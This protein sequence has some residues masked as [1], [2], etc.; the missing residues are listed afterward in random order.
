MNK[1][2]LEQQLQ[3]QLDDAMNQL[4]MKDMVRMYNSLVERCFHGCVR[5]FSSRSLSDKEELCMYRCT[6]KFLRHS[7]KVARVFAEQSML[8]QEQ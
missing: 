8:Q 2:Q 3:T 5:D 6:D 4:Q 7:A 1:E